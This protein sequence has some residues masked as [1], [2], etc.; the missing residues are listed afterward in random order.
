MV[1]IIGALMLLSGFL[2]TPL[3]RSAGVLD[4][5]FGILV[6]G[7]LGANGQYLLLWVTGAVLATAAALLCY[8]VKE[9]AE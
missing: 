9:P 8:T 5:S 4:L 7:V 3:C 2:L 6:G 1:L